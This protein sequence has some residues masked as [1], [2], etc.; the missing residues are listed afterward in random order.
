MMRVRRSWWTTWRSYKR[1]VRVT[2]WVLRAPASRLPHQ[3]SRLP[4]QVS[5]LPHRVSRLPRRVSRLQPLALRLAQCHPVLALLAPAMS[6]PIP[7]LTGLLV[8]SGVL[9]VRVEKCEDAF[10]WIFLFSRSELLVL[11]LR[12]R[13]W[14]EKVWEAMLLC[15]REYKYGNMDFLES[16]PIIGLGQVVW[17]ILSTAMASIPSSM[18]D[19]STRPSK[20]KKMKFHSGWWKMANADI[21][22]LSF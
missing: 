1:H 14:G 17:N 21:P 20:K 11:I 22:G 7:P 4:H 8:L 16:I 19:I 15:Y 5:R 18:P 6:H 10:F 3:V 9:D 2:H 12:S 13:Y